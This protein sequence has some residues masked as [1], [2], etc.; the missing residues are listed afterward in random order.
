MNRPTE[1]QILTPTLR[2]QSRAEHLRAGGKYWA[3]RQSTAAC[4]TGAT[5]PSANRQS[6][7]GPELGGKFFS[8]SPGL[9]RE[10]FSEL[11]GELMVKERDGNQT[12]ARSQAAANW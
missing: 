3:T 2:P 5:A 8:A 4:L 1:L 9:T 7:G 12:L 11:M 6:R 10:Q